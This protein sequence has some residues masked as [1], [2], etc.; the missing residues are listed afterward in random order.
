M[1]YEYEHD[2]I[3]G[4]TLVRL[5]HD[6]L[7]SQVSDHAVYKIMV[8]EIQAAL[9]NDNDLRI[10]IR[11]LVKESIAK[12]NLQEVVGQAVKAHLATEKEGPSPAPGGSE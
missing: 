7:V 10:L 2:P 1:A 5:S 4:H 12:M 6:R 9:A 3:S 11:E 8:E